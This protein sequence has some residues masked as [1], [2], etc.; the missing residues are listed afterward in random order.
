MVASRTMKPADDTLTQAEQ[1]L[2]WA[3]FTV[4]ASRVAIYGGTA[5]SLAEFVGFHVLITRYPDLAGLEDRIIGVSM[6]T[7]ASGFASAVAMYPWIPAGEWFRRHGNSVPVLLFAL[8]AAALAVAAVLV[9]AFGE[10]T[11]LRMLAR[12]Y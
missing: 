10:A 11:A 7:M 1:A 3:W 4:P 8:I 9:L 12:N 6:L 5:L 2:A